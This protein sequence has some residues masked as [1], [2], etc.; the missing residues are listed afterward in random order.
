MGPK[1][2]QKTLQKEVQKEQNSISVLSRIVQALLTVPDCDASQQSW[3]VRTEYE[4]Y[5]I[6]KHYHNILRRALFVFNHE[7][8]IDRPLY[9]LKLYI[10]KNSF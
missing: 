6:G 7:I 8:V 3:Y 1:K 10:F 4:Y 2:A 9:G 5:S